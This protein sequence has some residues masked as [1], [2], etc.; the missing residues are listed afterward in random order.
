M[1]TSER[2]LSRDFR[3]AMR[4]SFSDARTSVLRYVTLCAPVNRCTTGDLTHVKVDLTVRRDLC[5]ERHG[6][7][8]Q[9]SD[10]LDGVAGRLEQRDDAGRVRGEQEHRGQKQHENRHP[11]GHRVQVHR[12]P[13]G[14]HAEDTG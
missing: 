9:I 5:G 12:V 8:R 10:G 11:Y 1:Y 2:K 4:R 13:C 14:A 3:Q 6:R 7:F